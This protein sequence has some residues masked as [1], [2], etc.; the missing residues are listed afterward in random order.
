M[1]TTIGEIY[2]GYQALISIINEPFQGE[3]SYMLSKLLIQMELKMKDIEDQKEIINKKY[4][5]PEEN[6]MYR[7]P[8]ENAKAFSEE[9]QIFMSTILE[10]DYEKI[11]VN[12]LSSVKL[13]I[14]QMK[15]LMPFFI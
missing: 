15:M 5:I 7:I 3:I 1:K 6:N 4:G 14:L 9:M 12:C 11:N 2:F 13:S 10:I 8:S